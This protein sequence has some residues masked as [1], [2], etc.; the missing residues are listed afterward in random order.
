MARDEPSCGKVLLLGSTVL[1]DGTIVSSNMELAR[2]HM[3]L[4]FAK[5]LNWM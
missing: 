2:P 5:E 3:S 1:V 4:E